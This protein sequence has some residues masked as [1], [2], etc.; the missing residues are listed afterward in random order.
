MKKIVFVLF[1]AV[2]ILLIWQ[3]SL[4][5]KST[6]TGSHFDTTDLSS[7][8]EEETASIHSNR[9]TSKATEPR[10]VPTAR[11]QKNEA[12]APFVKRVLSETWLDLKENQTSGGRRRVRVVETT[13]K[14][15]YLRLEEKV[16]RDPIT[17]E[18]KTKRLRA[19]VAD[20][21]I[22]GIR[23]NADLD[24][25]RNRLRNQG[26]EIR[27]SKLRSSLLV[28]LPE[29]DQTESQ[30]DTI[31]ELQKFDEFIKFAEPDWLVYPCATPNDPA[32]ADGK[33][34]HLFNDG[35]TPGSFDDLD[36]DATD[37][38][39][40]ARTA[41]EV[42]VA[43][44][45]SGI[46]YTHEDLAPNMWRGL[47]LH[48][49]DAYDDDDDPMDNDGHGTHCAGIIGARGNNGRG[50]TG[51]AWEVQLMALR[52][53]GPEGGAT[54]DA[55]RAINFARLNGADVI[56]ASWGAGEFS[57]ALYDAIEDCY[58]ASIPFVA[59]AGNHSADNDKRA[60]YPANFDLGNIVSVAASDERDLFAY[61]TNRGRTTVDT[62]APGTDIWSC[63]ISSD[64]DYR[65]RSGTSAAASQVAGG[66][67]LA[68]HLFP[69]KTLNTLIS[70]LLQARDQRALMQ[71]KIK[72]GG[73]FNLGHLLN[74][75]IPPPSFDDFSNAYWI[76]SGTFQTTPS[77]RNF[78]RSQDEDNYS[79]NTGERSA[80]FRWTAP[81]SGLVEL[82]ATASSQDISV[83]AF[84][85]Q[86]QTSLSRI[87]DNFQERPV[88]TSALQFEVEAGKTYSFSIDSRYPGIQT[89][90]FGFFF[91]PPND[92]FAEAGVIASRTRF[93][94]FGSNIGATSESFERW[95]RRRTENKS[96]W[97]QW[98]APNDGDIHLTTQSTTIDTLLVVYTGP[99]SE[100]LTEIVSNDDRSA[101]DW[102]SDVSFTATA[103]TTYHILIDS[104]SSDSDGYTVLTGF[105]PGDLFIFDQPVSQELRLG[106]ATHFQVSAGGRDL[107][108]QWE[109]NGEAIPGAILPRLEIPAL[110]TE[111]LG[112]YRV[113]VYHD[114]I[115]RY[116]DVVTL[117]EI[118]T[119]P[120][121][122]WHSP[123]ESFATGSNLELHVGVIG[124]APLN[125]QWYKDG[126]AIPGA[127]SERLDRGE[128]SEN[129][130]ADYTVKIQNSRGSTTAG[131]I[132]IDVQTKFQDEFSYLENASASYDVK[133]II[134][135]DGL[136][137]AASAAHNAI[138]IST[139][140][141]GRN[142]HHQ[143]LRE[144]HPRTALGAGVFLEY[145]NG[146]WL[147]GTKALSSTEGIDLILFKST[148]LQNWESIYS[149]AYSLGNDLDSTFFKG[150]FYLRGDFNVYRSL[151]GKT[152]IPQTTPDG[153]SFRSP[154]SGSMA[155]NE[156][157]IIVLTGNNEVL[158]LD[159]PGNPWQRVTVDQSPTLRLDDA[160]WMQDRFVVMDGARGFESPDGM[161]W[162]ATGI[163]TG[164][165][166]DRTA[167][168]EDGNS[169]YSFHEASRAYI[170]RNGGL[171]WTTYI[172]FL[173]GTSV[174]IPYEDGFILGTT[175]GSLFYVEDLFETSYPK[176]FLASSLPTITRTG[177]QF[178]IQTR[179]VNSSP[180]GETWISSERS[181]LGAILGPNTYS[182]LPVGIAGGFWW[183][184]GEDIEQNIVGYLRGPT[185]GSRRSF[186]IPGNPES[187][188]RSIVEGPLGILAL[189]IDDL[190]NSQQLIRSQDG[191][192]TWTQISYP[193]GSIGELQT[194]GDAYLT[195]SFSGNHV[196]T[197]LI[198][199]VS[200]GDFQRII[201][202]NKEYWGWTNWGLSKSSD[203]LNWSEATPFAGPVVGEQ[204]VSFKDAVFAIHN[205]VLYYTYNGLR[206][207][208]L[209]VAFPAFELAASADVLLVLGD[210]GQVAKFGDAPLPAPGLEIL[211]PGQNSN[212]ELGSYVT[213]RFTSVNG[214]G[215]QHPTVR[216]FYNDQLVGELNAPPYEFQF[217]AT[218]PGTH[219][220]HAESRIGEGGIT[221]AEK[222]IT[223]T[224]SGP[225][226]R[227]PEP[228]ADFSDKSE[229]IYHNGRYFTSTR[230]SLDGITW[231]LISGPANLAFVSNP[232]SGNGVMISETSEDGIRIT[233][234]GVNWIGAPLPATLQSRIQ[235]NNGLFWAIGTTSSPT[236]KVMLTSSNGL[237]WETKTMLV[238]APDFETVSGDPRG[239]LMG[240]SNQRLWR[241][242]DGGST[243]EMIEELAYTTNLVFDGEGFF[244]V[245][246]QFD[247]RRLGQT[248]DGR[249]FEWSEPHPG[250]SRFKLVDRVLFAQDHQNQTLAVS[251]GAS[252]F[253]HLAESLD[254]H[255]II[256]GE[257]EW[258][259]ATGFDRFSTQFPTYRSRDGLAWED[260]ST[261]PV[262]GPATL[263]SSPDGLFLSG[264]DG[265]LWKQEWNFS[266][267]QN[268]LPP[269]VGTY[270]IWDLTEGEGTL[271]A[272]NYGNEI[273]RS[274]DDGLTWISIFQSSD[275]LRLDTLLFRNGV[276]LAF[277]KGGTLLRS[278]DA[279]TF[280]DI[281]GTS[282]AEQF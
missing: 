148:D 22:V 247:P 53:L 147:C 105:R 186:K 192:L 62:A 136:W 96:I 8:S 54:S 3:F 189:K 244:F 141:D 90:S 207:V 64:S 63:G 213:A 222:K 282:G 115:T 182:P 178:I 275:D 59:A 249:L 118:T 203:L 139:S 279:T 66:L 235:F 134:K 177:G 281:T 183:P 237:N 211:E 10:T 174:G 71:W 217:Q 257:D 259:Y 4:P 234:D 215:G 162:T 111:N 273:I 138:R 34:W 274:D 219:L 26:Y 93:R 25:A 65:Y 23:E 185:P 9:L 97:Y 16:F 197:N 230:T 216:L 31:T 205:R 29:F 202:H 221:L 124:T 239:L 246:G 106:E 87:Q 272:I 15:P 173:S 278:I 206:W 35:L 120:R 168:F 143:Y 20:H 108:Y 69:E 74:G 11:A 156:D 240:I 39:D 27:N 268:L 233:Q 153:Q 33:L 125:Y 245:E 157:A 78:T 113:S 193:F 260:H 100:N 32:F 50:T 2:S 110:L 24:S 172:D 263:F 57:Q 198:D 67:A 5:G 145:G 102:T 220:I 165:F 52:F 103:G 80:W 160:V 248:W 72:S 37:A 132:E 256:R 14:H 241:S 92:D 117:S 270:E 137:V 200:I 99:D 107:R 243:W 94:V 151:D 1:S 38:W 184:G 77:N 236:T 47:P 140:E 194:A 224:P 114:L 190:D 231:H 12:K 155:N 265:S 28:K 18:E 169:L 264:D 89:Y 46:R 251:N 43:V 161:N 212:V 191:G 76:T 109:L 252:T 95:R 201:L 129:D 131:P 187:Y 209:E 6:G 232:L 84:E 58:D 271:L 81:V 88:K 128:I 267:W 104:Y 21:L 154:F 152:W 41:P 142:W 179:Q 112:E 36:I 123:N 149:K 266:E 253:F 242:F 218:D 208:K 49:I 75:E 170:S 181:E 146:F 238:P 254:F 164:P 250:F 277:A 135:K 188:L 262:S 79:P 98:I 255:Q 130:Q 70:D 229:V 127:T 101:N 61:F 17:G 150:F 167:F 163:D 228:E 171:H 175:R 13:F 214:M 226:N 86:S 7:S 45:D 210:T 133:K 48:G 44:I 195:S 85:G 73:R 121:G 227:L 204:V 180:D 269:L 55:I 91:H 159:D 258:L 176:R 68:R 276:W 126:V 19:S 122:L 144:R 60:Q 56:N 199:W 119:A 223:V 116:S 158:Y 30:S 166:S 51:V 42:V 196:S 40:F 82:Q 280:T 261:S 225:I 83:V